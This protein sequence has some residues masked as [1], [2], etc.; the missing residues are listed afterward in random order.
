[1]VHDCVEAVWIR[2]DFEILEVGRRRTSRKGESILQPRRSKPSRPRDQHSSPLY[3]VAGSQF[4]RCR[5]VGSR[6]VKTQLGESRCWLL[7]HELLEGWQM[8]VINAD[9]IHYGGTPSLRT[10]FVTT[11][12]LAFL[13]W[14]YIWIRV[15]RLLTC[16]QS[17]RSGCPPC[18]T[19]IS[20]VHIIILARAEIALEGTIHCCQRAIRGQ[21]CELS[22]YTADETYGVPPIAS[23]ASAVVVL[24]RWKDEKWGW[25]P[26]R[27][28]G[29]Q[30]CDSVFH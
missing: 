12:R 1:M 9:Q 3:I 4:W 18:P 2:L 8:G 19:K 16:S 26:L 30:P 7:N 24:G 6:K 10:T 14:D 25:P 28:Q 23:A 15:W 21:Q 29:L 27:L 17:L 20:A 5:L 22:S 11:P 13:I